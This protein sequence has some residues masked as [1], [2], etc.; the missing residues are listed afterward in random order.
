M[1]EQPTVHAAITRDSGK[2]AGSL[3]VGNQEYELDGKD[4]NSL[5]TGVITRVMEIAQ[6][7]VK[8]VNVRIEDHPQNV[9]ELV[10]I[11]EDGGVKREDTF[12]LLDPP[13]EAPASAV[14]APVADVAP[15]P[16]LVTEIPAQP[17]KISPS[18]QAFLAA[19][20]AP[21]APSPE[22]AQASF[23][24]STFGQRPRSSQGAVIAQEGFNVAL[25]RLTNGMLRLPA[26]SSEARRAR[27]V[28]VLQAAPLSVHGFF[29]SKGGGGKTTSLYCAAAT[30]GYHT[31]HSLLALDGNDNHGT[32]GDKGRRQN[33]DATV[34]DVLTAVD[35]FAE[36]FPG[37]PV[38]VSQI[39][40]FLHAQPEG[41]SVLPS[42]SKAIDTKVLSA[43]ELRRLY[44]LIAPSF[45]HI[46]IDTGNN[47]DGD[48][49]TSTIQ[50]AAEVSTNY[51]FT[52]MGKIDSAR[53]AFATMD[54]LTRAGFGDKVRNSVAIVSRTHTTAKEDLDEIIDF[55]KVRVS[56]YVIVPWDAELDRGRNI[57]FDRLAPETRH[58]YLD[59]A[60]AIMDPSS[61]THRP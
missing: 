28:A 43:P 48:G 4:R 30:I 53:N 2:W 8:T 24:T 21:E 38:P 32:L 5:Y 13:A 3:T 51:V 45:S 39:A 18:A 57:Q 35:G 42:Q 55:L 50:V 31:A 47:I 20:E 46:F 33:H 11:S 36:K 44:D 56:T 23:D 49:S 54:Y 26:S 25:N 59:A 34:R 52:M 10:S 61:R 15:A 14:P 29:N 27:Q 6:R 60:V 1:T 9:V 7:E 12:P 37:V 17:T 58:A 22:L 19:V 16:A 41:F 40:P